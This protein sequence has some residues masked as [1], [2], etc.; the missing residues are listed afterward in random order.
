MNFKTDPVA[1]VSNIA[2]KDLVDK[3]IFL[4]VRITVL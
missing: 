3:N 2:I 4:K 1:L